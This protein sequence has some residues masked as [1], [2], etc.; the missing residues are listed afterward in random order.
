MADPWFAA[1]VLTG[2]AFAEALAIVALV[3]WLRRRGRR[4][5]HVEG[6][7]QVALCEIR[8]LRRAQ[9]QKPWRS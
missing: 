1:Q 2:A 6:E 7:L 9:G 8:G 3:Q 5:R 4:L